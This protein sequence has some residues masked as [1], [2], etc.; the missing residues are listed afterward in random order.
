M[1]S[2]T[3]RWRTST[4]T[5]SRFCSATGRAASR[6]HQ[7]RRGRLFLSPS[8][9]AI[10]TRT[11]SSTSR[12]R[13]S[14]RQRLGS[15]RR[16]AGRLRG[17]NQLRRGRWSSLRHDG[18]LQRGRQTR[19]RDGELQLQQRLCSARQRGWA[20]SLR[21]PT[22][23]RAMLLAPSRRATSTRT[24]SSTWRRRT[25]SPTTSRFCSATGRAA[26][27]GNQ[28]RR[29]RWSSLRHDGRLQ[30]RRQSRP[31]DGEPTLRQ[32]LGAAQRLHGDMQHRARRR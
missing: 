19:P 11:A 3:S 32:R 30:R 1:A 6:R 25:A 10:S 31:R 20:A 7:L 29:G 12:R 23:A 15:A 13:T 22:S 14:L 16:R 27:R 28:F 24:A 5:T 2:S 4:P 17:G 26:S 18:R 8:R 9:R 21:Q